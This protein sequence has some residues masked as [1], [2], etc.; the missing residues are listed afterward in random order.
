MFFIENLYSQEKQRVQ[1]KDNQKFSVAH[2]TG[3]VIYDSKRMPEK[4]RDFLP[5]E[6]IETMRSSGNPI[7]SKLFTN[8]LDKTG[9]L[10]FSEERK[11]T[12]FKVISKVSYFLFSSFILLLEYSLQCVL[13]TVK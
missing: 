5:S 4:N 2:Y 1:V 10:I 11:S 6:I 8:K 9:N 7:I 13:I 3:R 12:R